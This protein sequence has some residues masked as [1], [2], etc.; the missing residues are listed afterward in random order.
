MKVEIK[1]FDYHTGGDVSCTLSARNATG[2]AYWYSTDKTS[3]AGGTDKLSVNGSAKWGD[4]D[5]YI[6][7]CVMPVNGS[8]GYTKIYSYKVDEFD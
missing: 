2:S 1:V 6:L 5:N 3:L 8:K 7:K 4:F